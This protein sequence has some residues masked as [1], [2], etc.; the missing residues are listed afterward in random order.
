MGSV[1]ATHTLHIAS[2]I[3]DYTT[4]PETAIR[5]AM[6]STDRNHINKFEKRFRFVPGKRSAADWNFLTPGG[7]AEGNTPSLV[8]LPKNEDCE[9][10]ETFSSDPAGSKAGK[11]GPYVA[12][13]VCDV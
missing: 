3:W 7:P 13:L 12:V 10:V 5:F 9:F 2:E 8:K 4:G 1:A 6:G 11:V